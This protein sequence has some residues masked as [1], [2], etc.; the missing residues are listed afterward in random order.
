MAAVGRR[1]RRRS[2]KGGARSALAS[3]D[4]FRAA[5]PLRHSGAGVLERACPASA[6]AAPGMPSRRPDACG[7]D[8]LR[9]A[10][11]LA[12]LHATPHDAEA[13]ARASAGGAPRQIRLRHRRTCKAREV[14]W[15]HTSRL[16]RRRYGSTGGAAR[17]VAR[18][19]PASRR[20]PQDL[21]PAP[22]CRAAGSPAGRAPPYQTRSTTRRAR[23]RRRRTTPF[24]ATRRQ[25]AE[26]RVGT[27][28]AAD[29]VG[30][31]PPRG[32]GGGEARAA[33]RAHAAQ[34]RRGRRRLSA[35]PRRSSR[36]AATRARPVRRMPP[37]QQGRV[38]EQRRARRRRGRAGLSPAVTT[39]RPRAPHA[40][41][42]GRRGGI[43]ATALRRLDV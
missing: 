43:T 12:A 27:R 23:A 41:E 22:P 19:A 8:D 20:A 11:P 4:G 36:G 33:E 15:P 30:R 13:G 38:R 29:G 42:P 10:P 37:R 7:L 26:S 24:A 39:R 32:A 1:R 31:T 6:K 14:A 25:L 17:G 9:A 35:S 28:R 21:R 16:H 18:D 5:N 3:G 40:L 34:R 2:A